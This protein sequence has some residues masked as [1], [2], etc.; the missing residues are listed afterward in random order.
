MSR[1]TDS[2]S[3]LSHPTQSLHLFAA[4]VRI[5][6]TISAWIR[7]VLFGG[8]VIAVAEH[9][10]NLSSCLRKCHFELE[11]SVSVGITSS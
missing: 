9:F 5:F 11:L 4:R 3:V 10:F 7:D 6:C 1:L 8:G 2:S